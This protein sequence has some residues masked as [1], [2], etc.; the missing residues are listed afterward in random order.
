[1]GQYVIGIDAGGTMTKAALFDMDGVEIAC[2]HSRNVMQ[3][4]HPGW[5]ERDPEEMWQAATLAVRQVI[6]CSGVSPSD[7]D[8]V[9]VAGYGGGLYLMDHDG[10]SVRAGI[11]STDARAVDTVSDTVSGHLRARTAHLRGGSHG[12]PCC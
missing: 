9:S 4:P 3:A 5:T 8:A 12:R 2:A 1:M 10:H 6:E 11:M 7:I